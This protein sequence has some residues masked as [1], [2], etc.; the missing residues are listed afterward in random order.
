[1]HSLISVSHLLGDFALRLRDGTR[2]GCDGEV[3]MNGAALQ[4]VVCSRR[5][6]DA[7]MPTA[8]TKACCRIGRL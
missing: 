2:E 4:V 7:A 6:H 5:Q 3:T 8:I 1:L